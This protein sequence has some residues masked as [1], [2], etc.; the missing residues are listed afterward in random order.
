M[1]RRD[2]HLRPRGRSRRHLTRDVEATR[3]RL[4]DAGRQLFADHPFDDVTVRDICRHAGV[5]LALVNYHFGDKLGLYSAVMSEVIDAIREFNALAM[6]AP[7]GSSPDARLQRFIRAFLQRIFETKGEGSWVHKFIQHELNRPTEAVQR[8][9]EEAIV[10]RLRYLSA[11]VTELLDCTPDDPRVMQCVGSVHGLCLVYSRM[12]LAPK[13]KL[14]A[15][16]LTPPERPGVEAAVAHVT[17]FSLAGI[18]AM[19]STGDTIG[20]RVV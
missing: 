6:N 17:A 20:V 11:A 5:N 1:R 10:P 14:V 3:R 18:K 4:L 8:I 9:M 12:L 19:R 7:E 15:P 16:D 2:P 13:L